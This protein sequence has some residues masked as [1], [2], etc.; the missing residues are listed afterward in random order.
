M[1]DLIC[2][3]H[4]RWNFVWQRPQHLLSRMSR[5]FRVFFVEEPV[6]SAEASAPYLEHDLWE[7]DHGE[8]VHVI[9]M[10]YPMAAPRWIGHGEPQ[11]QPVY[12]ALL[13]KYLAAQR[14]RNPHVWLYT[15][16]ASDFLSALKPKS[17]IYDVMDQLSAF[18][19]APAQLSALDRELLKRADI[20]FTGGVSL[21]YD[22]APYAR[23]IHAFPSGVDSAH[24]SQ[25]ADGGLAR[26]A[27]MPSGKL[28]VVGYYGV[29][30]E[31]MDFDLLE[32]MASLHPEW[33]IVLVG[34]VVKIDPADTPQAA[35]IHYPGMRSYDELPAYLSCFDAALIPFALTDATRFLS[36]T[37]TLEYLAARK[38]VVSTPI[39]DVIELYKSVVRIG[40]THT[41]F[42][43]QVEMALTHKPDIR[44]RR[45][46]DSLLYQHSWDVI[47]DRM[48]RLMGHRVQPSRKALME[49]A[50]S[51][52]RS[53]DLR[54]EAQGGY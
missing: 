21:Y 53:A 39:H 29:I 54:E 30:D 33:Q 25:A 2:I 40:H 42:I 45:L 44:Q 24:F 31:R 22:K 37:K 51:T 3:S 35:N 26:P 7:G 4:L 23:N 9:R 50:T 20:V 5:H 49:Q 18:K 48:L 1:Q 13:N 10:I 19:G 6:A 16:M 34:P 8:K 12:A 27:D 43:N 17:V 41:H 52:L 14:V 32:Q 15:P 38:P 28:P 11:T 46:E 47:A 36:P